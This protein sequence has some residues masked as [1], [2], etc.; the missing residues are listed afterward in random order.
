MILRL[1]DSSYAERLTAFVQSLGLR[2]TATGT[3]S[4]ALEREIPPDELRIYL[5]VWDVLHPG[6]EVTVG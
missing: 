5:R 1:S 6:V 3:D 2:T 4:V